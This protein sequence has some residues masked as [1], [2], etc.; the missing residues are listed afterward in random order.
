FFLCFLV[1][2]GGVF[3]LVAVAFKRSLKAKMDSERQ[4]GHARSQRPP[5]R[6]GRFT[7][8]VVDD[9]FW[10]NEPSLMRGSIIH[11]RYRHG[12]GIRTGH[13]AFEPGPHGHFVYT[14]ET[15]SDI[16]V[17]DVTP[18]GPEARETWEDRPPSP[19][20]ST[21][22]PPSSFTGYPSAY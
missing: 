4:P 7:P 5:G 16:E 15:P 1:F 11:Y 20:P 6:P 17:Y 9:G 14:G 18:P 13:C 21:S 12:G 22:P 19:P 2:V 3:I 10:L 8:R